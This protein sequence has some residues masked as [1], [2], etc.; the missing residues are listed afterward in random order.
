MDYISN[1]V[2]QFNQ[3]CIF[4]SY[5]V[6]K[7][8]MISFLA[9]VSEFIS[10]GC[11]FRTHLRVIKLFKTGE[12]FCICDAVAIFATFY[13]F[14]ARID[15]NLIKQQWFKISPGYLSQDPEDDKLA[16][17]HHLLKMTFRE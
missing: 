12:L 16:P 5:Q 17:K 3:C 10:H 9:L 11:I 15:S 6:L 2:H 1:V 13:T 7:T 14:S 8:A 4:T